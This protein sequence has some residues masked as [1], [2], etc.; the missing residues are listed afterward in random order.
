MNFRNVFLCLLFVFFIVPQVGASEPKR[1]TSTDMQ[2]VY[3]VGNEIAEGVALSFGEGLK[4]VDSGVKYS[5]EHEND[6]LTVQ[7]HTWPIIETT[8]MFSG[9]RI[10]SGKAS[11]VLFLEVGYGTVVGTVKHIKV[12]GELQQDS[13]LLNTM[14]I[15]TEEGTEQVML[16]NGKLFF[17]ETG[18]EVPL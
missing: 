4:L 11:F 17:A 2:D 5:I 1:I 13:P 6:T 16:N 9:T 12:D 14:F 18:E 8:I 10:G 3:A 7:P 15:E